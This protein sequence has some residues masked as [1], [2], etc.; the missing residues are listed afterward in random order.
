MVGLRCRRSTGAF[1]EPETHTDE[2]GTQSASFVRRRGLGHEAKNQSTRYR[3]DLGLP[4]QVC[5]FRRAA[6]SRRRPR[7]KCNCGSDTGS[8]RRTAI[9]HLGSRGFRLPASPHA[10]HRSCQIET[11]AS[12]PA[13]GEIWSRAIA[14]VTASLTQKQTFE[15][16]SSLPNFGHWFIFANDRF[17]SLAI[18]SRMSW[19]GR[20]ESGPTAWPNTIHLSYGATGHSLTCAA[21]RDRNLTAS[22]GGLLATARLEVDRWRAFAVN[23]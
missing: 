23:A 15:R 12:E 14:S 2:R 1:L 19:W 8:Q 10:D 13:N 6:S 4:N 16:L 11:L 21:T 18:R 7:R 17:S 3:E 22:N 5:L 9:M 20:E